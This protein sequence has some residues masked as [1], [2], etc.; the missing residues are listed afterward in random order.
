MNF[1]SS[2]KSIFN[3]EE[4]MIRQ[5]S[6]LMFFTVIYIMSAQVL[7]AFENRRT[8]PALTD[9][10]ANASIIDDYLKNQMNW[11]N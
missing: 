11:R 5:I 2:I 7:Y 10:V 9:N 3:A 8:H 6:F 4:K 1:L